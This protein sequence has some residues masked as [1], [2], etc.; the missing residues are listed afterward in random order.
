MK[1]LDSKGWGDSGSWVQVIDEPTWTDPA[2][3]ANTLA[4]MRLYKSV[5]SRIKI[6]QTRWPAGGGAAAAAGSTVENGAGPAGVPPYAEPLLE[7]VDWWCPHVRQT[8][9]IALSVC[10][11]LA[12]T[13][14]SVADQ[15][16]QWTAPGVPE[17]M[18]ALRAKRTAAGGSRPWHATVYDNG[19]PII[20]APWERLRSQA[21][22]V[23]R[24]LTKP[25]VK[26]SSHEEI[27][28]RGC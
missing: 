7:L 22:D 3:L 9:R 1:Y 28:R 24:H 11:N 27:G 17:A 25:C 18:G 16:C 13:D 15:V 21:L 20:E 2:T 12:L 4:I 5:D 8:D 10:K 23:C 19:V 6:Y 26:T 14:L